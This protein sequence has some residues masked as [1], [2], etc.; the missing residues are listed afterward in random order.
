MQFAHVKAPFSATV[1]AFDVHPIE[2]PGALL[3]QVA[4]PC[5]TFVLIMPTLA[6]RVE[7]NFSFRV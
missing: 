1:V 4:L 3:G 6:R 5:S 2:I 7:S